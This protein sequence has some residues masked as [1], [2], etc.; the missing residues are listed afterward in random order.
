MFI[1]TNAA[2]K[3]A[4]PT[5]SVSSPRS[6]DGSTQLEDASPLLTSFVGQDA[7]PSYLEAT[8]PVAW[9]ARPSDNEAAGLLSFDGRSPVS[10]R[11]DPE[12]KHYAL[13]YRRRGWREH[14]SNHL[15]KWIS[16]LFFLTMVAAIAAAAIHSDK[17]KATE[18]SLLPAP[19]A[20]SGAAISADAQS[21]PIRWP[22]RCGKHYKTKSEDFDFGTLQELHVQ[23]AVHQ[24]DG[25]YKRVMG[26]IHIAQAPADQATGTIRAKL[27]YAVS[28]SVDV[29]SVK[30]ASTPDGLVI[31]DPSFPDGFDGLR[32]GKA[33]LGISVVIY[34]APGAT[35]RNLK[36]ASTHLG[37][38]VHDGAS[39]SVKNETSISL[40][41]GTMEFASFDSR[42]TRLE[43]ISGSISG[44]YSLFDL[45]SIKTKSGSVNVNVEPK[46]AS[47]EAPKPALFLANSLSGSIRADF[48]RKRIPDR[49]YQVSLDTTVGSIDGMFIHGSKTAIN[50]V[51]GF[52]TADLLPFKSGDYE[53]TLDTSTRSGQTSLNIRSP[54]QNAGVKMNKLTS[55]HKSKSG[56]VDLTYPQE[57]EGHLEGTSVSGSL[58]LQGKN[59]ELIH[60]DEEPGKNRVE[61]KKGDGASSMVFDTVSG[62]CDVKVG[63][64]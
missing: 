12:A 31:G 24:L 51:A 22:S 52:V 62:S 18:I 47:E 16:A 54:Y 1:D 39:F 59:L 35:L 8:T 10:S 42:E 55:T 29:D 2:N 53:S 56:A 14:C 64:L 11:A 50:S 43:T 46:N 7:P 3:V 23:E 15:W 4:R 32:A 9:S 25:P 41:S 63:N 33:C 34:M 49:D 13:S 40:T 58:H 5:V 44:K 30:Y 61:A 6:E 27:S 26:W 48:E 20:Q 21:F 38:Q 19:Q 28:S 60:Q 37:M 17:H 36:V 57:W 45:L